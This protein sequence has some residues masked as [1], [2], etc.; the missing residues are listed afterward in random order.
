WCGN[1]I[2]GAARAYGVSEDRELYAA[3][4]NRAVKTLSKVYGVKEKQSKIKLLGAKIENM[5]DFRVEGGWKEGVAVEPIFAF[6][7]AYNFIQSPD[8]ARQSVAVY[9]AAIPSLAK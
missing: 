1:V 2:W 5:A 4:R 6:S 7:R 9:D 8:F 3:E